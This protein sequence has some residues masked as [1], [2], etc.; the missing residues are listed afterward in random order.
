[1][2]ENKLKSSADLKNDNNS[3][4]L[5]LNFNGKEFESDT[6]DLKET[7]M[8]VKPFFLKTKLIFSCTNPSG[9]TCDKV[10][11]VKQA[12]MIWRNK[13]YMDMFI[14]QLIFKEHV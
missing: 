10:I 6:Y 8:S 3:Y 12:K 13:V 5:K 1:M 2:E 7:I 11:L 4:H 9:W 14:N